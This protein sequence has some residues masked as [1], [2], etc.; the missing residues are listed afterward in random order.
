MIPSTQNAIQFRR[1]ILFAMASR[2]IAIPIQ[3][4]SDPLWMQLIANT[5]PVMAFATVW[6][7]LVSF[8]V[9]L[10]GVALGT[11][12]STS[13]G[14]GGV[15]N[16]GATSGPGGGPNSSSSPSATILTVIQITAYVVYGFL[17]ITFSVFRRIAAAVLLY[18][19]LCCVYATLLGMGVYFC[20]RLLGLLLPALGGKWKSPLALRLVA[21]SSA[22]LL[23]F[24]AQTFC[25]ARKVVQSTVPTSH[26]GN[27]PYW[28]FQYGALELLP[29]ILFLLLLHPKRIPRASSP[30]SSDENTQK[31]SGDLP[32]LGRRTPPLRSYHRQTDSNDSKSGSALLTPS[33][34]PSRSPTPPIL[35]QQHATAGASNLTK[36]TT[37]LLSA[38]SNLRYGG[39]ATLSGS[40]ADATT[41][42][43]SRHQQQGSNDRSTTP[44]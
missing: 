8:F 11:N 16:I 25:F 37:P 22:C 5:F 31:S 1:L 38:H 18:A 40:H 2:T 43:D 44:S 39:S 6:C 4:Y 15:A 34:Q 3:I 36:E 41:S 35:Q 24:T 29:G 12:I 30:E 26:K 23:V 33:P 7:W 42:I 20:P 27:G 17:I 21:C 13:V 14:S 19:L 28:W 9:Q 32:S 10:V